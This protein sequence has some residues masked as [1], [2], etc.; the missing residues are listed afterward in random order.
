MYDELINA[1]YPVF[2]VALLVGFISTAIFSNVS[3]WP[4]WVTAVITG[5]ALYAVGDMAFTFFSVADAYQPGTL[6]SNVIDVFW[7]GCYV[8]V[9]LGAFL[10]LTSDE[11]VYAE[12]GR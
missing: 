7:M 3:K 5:I 10:R 8:F 9:F 6:V 4:S 11:D 12:V 2:D 1:L